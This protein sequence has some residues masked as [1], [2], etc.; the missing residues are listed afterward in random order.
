MTP[1]GHPTYAFDPALDLVLDKKTPLPGHAN[2]MQFYAY[3]SGGR[4]L[5]K[6]VYYSIGG[7]FVVSDEELQRMKARGPE[8]P[9]KKVP[10]PFANAKEMLAMAARSGLSIADMKRANEEIFLSREELDAGLDRIW[11]AMLGLYRARSCA[12]RHHAR[13]PEGAPACAAVA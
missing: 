12:G 3:D 13:R 8:K 5:L 1:A 10:Y 7:G 6:R 9:S 4:L 11:A 2:G